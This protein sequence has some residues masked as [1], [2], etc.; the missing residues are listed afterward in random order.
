[1]EIGVQVVTVNSYLGVFIGDYIVN[2]EW[3]E[4]EVQGW[5]T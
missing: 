2:T 1:M 4:G 3:L 5:T